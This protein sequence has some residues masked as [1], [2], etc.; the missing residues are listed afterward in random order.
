VG[1][2]PGRPDR[3]VATQRPKTVKRV[4]EFAGISEDA[5]WNALVRKSLAEGARH[6]PEM[7]SREGM[8]VCRDPG[9]VVARGLLFDQR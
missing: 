7:P 1:G 9:V 5:L 3:V 2:W 6:Q 4:A 8:V